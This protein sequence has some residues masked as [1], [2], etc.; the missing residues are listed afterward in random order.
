MAKYCVLI[1]VYQGEKCK[2]SK[3]S[4]FA[5]TLW[6]D[7]LDDFDAVNIY[8]VLRFLFGSYVIIDYEISFVAD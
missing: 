6:L 2:A 5:R 7:R 1:T 3:K 4:V 8:S